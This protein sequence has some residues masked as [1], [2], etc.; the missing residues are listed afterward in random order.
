ML[1]GVII[2]PGSIV[3]HGS[4]ATPAETKRGEEKTLVT[5]GGWISGKVREEVADSWIVD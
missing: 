4:G 2:G 5:W 1:A 3:R